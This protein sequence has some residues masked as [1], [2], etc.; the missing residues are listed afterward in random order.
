MRI[1][2]TYNEKRSQSEAEAEFDSPETIHAIA[3][4]LASLGHVV[5]PVEVGRPVETLVAEIVD[6]CYDA[7]NDPAC[8]CDVDVGVERLFAAYR[9]RTSAPTVVAAEAALRACGYTPRRILT[10]GGSDANAFEAK[11][12]P[13]TNLA[14]G[15]EHNHETIERV[16]QSALEGM[17][18]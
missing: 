15:T 8:E 17:L 2:L 18:G 1:A 3:R 5:T 13:C 9:H 11:G 10:G 14:N 6:H 12:F 16:S 7:G 4:M